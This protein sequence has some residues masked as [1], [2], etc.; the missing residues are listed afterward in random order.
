MRWENANKSKRDEE[1]AQEVM[2]ETRAYKSQQMIFFSRIETRGN[3]EYHPLKHAAKRF[4]LCNEA[5]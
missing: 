4:T 2:F 3:I 1:N 5:S